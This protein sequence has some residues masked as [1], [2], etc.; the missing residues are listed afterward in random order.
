MGTIPLG[1]SPLAR[2][3]RSQPWRN[4]TDWRII[5]ARAGFTVSRSPRDRC[6]QDHPRSRGVYLSSHISAFSSAGSSPLARGLHLRLLALLVGMRIIPARAGFTQ[7]EPSSRPGAPDHPRSRGV[8]SSSLP[9]FGGLRGS[10]PLARGL[11]CRD[12]HHL[13]DPGIIPARAGFTHPLHHGGLR[14]QDHPRS[15]GVY[16]DKRTRKDSLY[17]SSPLARGLPLRVRGCVTPSGIIP[18]RAGFTPS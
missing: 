7:R 18:A 4:Y 12:V 5:P 3:L 15:R 1:S 16:L 2:G 17:G 10:S 11:P 13:D 6:G 8:Y 9:T 14:G